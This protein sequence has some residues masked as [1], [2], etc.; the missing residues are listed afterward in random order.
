MTR[1]SQQISI[2]QFDAQRISRLRVRP[3]T[4]G[5]DV[6]AWDTQD[7]PWSIEDGALDKALHAFVKEHRVGADTV[8]TVLPRHEVTTRILELPS[9]NREELTNMVRLSA[10]EFVPYSADELIIDQSV[11]RPLESGESQILAVLAHHDV[12]NNHLGMLRKAGIIDSERR[13]Q[14]LFY[15]ARPEALTTLE[16]FL[17]GLMGE[18]DAV[19]HLD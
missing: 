8:Y 4:K 6:L 18:Q 10:E 17:S 3:S 13:G 11:L 1:K 5:V 16:Q 2:L 9:H 14:W 7:G 12:V 19:A 15:F